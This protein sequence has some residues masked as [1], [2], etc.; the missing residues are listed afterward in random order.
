MSVGGRTGDVERLR[1]EAR[2]AQLYTR[3]YPP[4]REYCSRRVA[5]DEVDDAVADTF[6]T[7]WRRLDEVP[8]GEEESLMWTY[9]VAYRV[10][11]HRWRSTA[12]RRRLQDRLRTVD[13]RPTAAADEA[14]VDD[15]ECCLVLAALERLGEIDAEVLRLVAW[16]QL[17]ITEVAAVVGIEPSTARQR[18]HRARLH[19]AREYGQLESHST[20]TPA[21]PTRG[22]PRSPTPHVR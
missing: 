11:G 6:L 20:S 7:V 18:L 19:L 12:R 1:G 22:A 13:V 5:A 10:I 8:A 9:A 2:F 15:D 21:A 3:W 4:I 16:E 17:S 14:A